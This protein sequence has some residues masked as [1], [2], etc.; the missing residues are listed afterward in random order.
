MTVALLTKSS[1]ANKIVLLLD[2]SA[3]DTGFVSRSSVS[4][5]AIESLGLLLRYTA[6][7]HP[8]IA[9][10]SADEARARRS[11]GTLTRGGC[12][13]AGPES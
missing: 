8:V 6:T 7:P 1:R 4:S 11:C 12:R 2:A 10:I 13:R 3:F 5:A 9:A